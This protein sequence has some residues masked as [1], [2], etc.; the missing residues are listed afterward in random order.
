MRGAAGRGGR[1]QNP[2][3]FATTP[4]KLCMRVSACKELCKK[5]MQEFIPEFGGSQASSTP[6]KGA[7]D[8]NIL[9]SLREIAVPQRNPAE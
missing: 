1:V 8:I 3:G 4:V 9:N 2:P 6:R 7:A 5:V